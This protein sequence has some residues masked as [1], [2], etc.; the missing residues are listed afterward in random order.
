MAIY[1]NIIDTRFET[2]YNGSKEISNPYR[3]NSGGGAN[4]EVEV[5]LDKNSINPRIV[6]YTKEVTEEI[7]EL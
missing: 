4:M 3:E 2:V 5:K 1:V 7:T 6:I